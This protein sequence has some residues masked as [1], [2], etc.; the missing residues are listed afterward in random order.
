MKNRLTYILSFLVLCLGTMSAQQEQ[1]G[2]L[3]QSISFSPQFFQ[4]KPAFNYGLTHRGINLKVVYEAKKITNS[5]TWTYSSS[6][7]FGPSYNR[8]LGLTWHL[9]PVDLYKGY[10][11]RDTEKYPF[12]IGPYFSANYQWQLYPEL[13]SGHMNWLTAYEFG[14]RGTL[15]I[16]VFQRKWNITLSS[17]VVSLSS[18]RKD[19]PED[20]FYD[21]G[22]KD[23]IG[24]AHSNFS[25][26]YNDQ[27]NHTDLKISLIPQTSKRLT[28]S[29]SY[30]Y[31]GQHFDVNDRMMWH[32]FTMNWKLG[33][34]N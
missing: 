18:K 6:F 25:F 32:S 8:G 13:Q 2:N 7:A 27:Y 28:Y 11:V 9:T 1:S 23:F 21:L 30:E 22:L 34:I 14:V 24:N 16:T 15:G 31:V 5:K 12:E 3:I 29:Y 20:Y 17:A 10:H 4:I 19:S 33:K 26:G